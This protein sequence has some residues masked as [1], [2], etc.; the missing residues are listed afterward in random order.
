MESVRRRLCPPQ[1]DGSCPFA[2][3]SRL[4][5]KNILFSTD[6]PDASKT[7]PPYAQSLAKIYGSTI[8]LA[9]SIP[10]ESHQTTV[11]DRPPAQEQFGLAG[12]ES[13]VGKT[14]ER[15]NA[16]RDA[17]ENTARSRRKLETSLK[18]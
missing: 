16:S 7:A 11:I 4:A 5:L 8:L 1:G 14:C 17:E 9:H 2:H 10:P 15:S 12:G 3:A 6:F 13:A 18:G